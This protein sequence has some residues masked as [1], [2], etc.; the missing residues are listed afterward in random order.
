MEKEKAFNRVPLHVACQ[1]V[2]S[3][4][5]IRVLCEMEPKCVVETDKYVSF[6]LFVIFTKKHFEF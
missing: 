1:C 6:M 4:S 3:S 5:V 2:A